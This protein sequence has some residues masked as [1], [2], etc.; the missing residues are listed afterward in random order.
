VS[1]LIAYDAAGN[2]VATLDH[3]VARDDRGDVV[4]LIDFAAH[5]ANGGEHTDIWHV[6]NAA[7][8]KIWPE[9]I[10]S[11]AHE[12]KVELAGEPGRKQITALVHKDSGHRRERHMIEHAI[13]STPV[14]DGVRDIRHVVGGPQ[15]PLHLDE[16]GRTVHGAQTGT[17]AH[18]PL[19]GRSK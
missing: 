9:W 5:E 15:K 7:G 1:S 18:L 17:P 16:H 8:S 14:V 13:A 6:A 10:G 3:M 12:F 4:G 2:V 19:I 11:R